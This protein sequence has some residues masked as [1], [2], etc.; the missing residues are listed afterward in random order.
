MLQIAPGFNIALPET[1]R[2]F[3]SPADGQLLNKEDV[4]Q[5]LSNPLNWLYRAAQREP[6][7]LIETALTPQN[8]GGL[9]LELLT[10]A[11]VLAFNVSA[12][13][14][15][16]VC[17]M[18]RVVLIDY[19][20]WQRKDPPVPLLDMLNLPRRALVMHNTAI[21]LMLKRNNASAI[22]PAMSAV[23]QSSLSAKIRAAEGFYYVVKMLSLVTGAYS[24]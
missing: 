15:K 22:R 13:S 23:L 11:A 6:L 17:S 10:A 1:T 4:P 19:A 21:H 8:V 5:L 3:E 9:T 7:P 20:P 2:F 24:Q 12:S 14:V 16:P 18:G